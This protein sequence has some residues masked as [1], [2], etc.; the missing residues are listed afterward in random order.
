MQILLLEMLLLFFFVFIFLHVLIF[1]TEK[2]IDLGNV[3]TTT[4]HFV[5]LVANESSCSLRWRE[6]RNLAINIDEIQIDGVVKSRIWEGFL[7]FLS[8]YFGCNCSF[9]STVDDEYRT[10]GT[11]W[12]EVKIGFADFICNL[13]VQYGYEILITCGYFFRYR[14]NLLMNHLLSFR[15][16]VVVRQAVLRSTR[17]VYNYM[18]LMISIDTMLLFKF[19]GN[20]NKTTARVCEMVINLNCFISGSVSNSFRLFI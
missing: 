16:H 1:Y 7:F 3:T 5:W 2:C 18:C 12:N 19:D 10:I 4:D 17:Y 15:F 8:F 14:R 13:Y 6:V 9:T 20:S 11:D